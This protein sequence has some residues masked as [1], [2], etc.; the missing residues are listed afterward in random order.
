MWPEAAYLFSELAKPKAAINQQ[1][2]E[3]NDEIFK[4]SQ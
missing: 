2:T 1:E 3:R 4:V